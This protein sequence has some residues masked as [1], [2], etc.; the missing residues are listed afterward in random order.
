MARSSEGRLLALCGPTVRCSERLLLGKDRRS[1][2]VDAYVTL[3]TDD[4]VVSP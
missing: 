1:R 3:R 2:V 4:I